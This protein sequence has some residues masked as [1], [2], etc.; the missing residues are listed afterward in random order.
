MTRTSSSFVLVL[1]ACAACLACA[2]SSAPADGPKEVTRTDLPYDLSGEWNNV[3]ADLVAR[4]II[5][6]CL[7]SDWVDRWSTSNQGKKP[8]LRLFPIRNRTTAYI[9]YRFFTKQIEAA[10][11]RSGKVDVI[12]AEEESGPATSDGESDQLPQYDAAG[13]DFVFTGWI[14]SQDDKA[15]DKEV[16]AYLTSIE[17]VEAASKKKAWVGQKQIRKLIQH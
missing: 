12:A 16:R 13:A 2:G 15:G 17:I 3:D 4:A 1:A 11:V 7:K 10:L 6:E 5:D 9:D 8:V 14:V